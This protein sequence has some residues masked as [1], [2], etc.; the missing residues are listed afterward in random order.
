MALIW[1]VSTPKCMHAWFIGLVSGHFVAYAVC[2]QLWPIQSNW[3][4]NLFGC[5]FHWSPKYGRSYN[6]YGP[7][8]KE[9]A[10]L[11]N[12]IFKKW[13][14]YKASASTYNVKEFGSIYAKLVELSVLDRVM[15]QYFRLY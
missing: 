12:F 10:A 15:S 6:R 9:N 2:Y 1:L 7:V 5:R 8:R 14:Y 3:P 4:Y 13:H 11:S